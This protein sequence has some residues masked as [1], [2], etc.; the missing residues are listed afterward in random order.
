[1]AGGFWIRLANSDTHASTDASVETQV[2]DNAGT[3]IAENRRLTVMGYYFS[4]YS[5]SSLMYA[6]RLILAPEM[7]SSGD[8]TSTQPEDDDDMV[9]AK[10]YAHKGTPGYFQVRSKRTL[11]PDDH[12]WVQTFAIITADNIQWS[13]QA[14]VVGHG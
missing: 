8:L 14:Y 9:W 13:F 10:Y 12:L 7:I 4:L 5:E 2:L 11:G 6:A 1:M 3:S